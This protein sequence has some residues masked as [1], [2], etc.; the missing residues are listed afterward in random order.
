M[1]HTPPHAL[2]FDDALAR[3]VALGASHAMPVEHVPLARAH[4]RVL[5]VDVSAPIDLQPFDNSAMDGFALR[6]ADL[7]GDGATLLLAGEQFAGV[8]AGLAVE[9]GQCVRITTGAPMPA[10][11]DTVAIKEQV[12]VTIDDDG[13]RFVQVPGGLA[14]GANVRRAGEDARV[15]ERMLVAGTR[16]SPVQVSLASAL[17]IA[18]LAMARRPTVAVF[19][20]GDELV[21]PGLPLQR[22]QVYESNRELLMG[23]LRMQGLEP[24]A[25]PTLPDEAGRM[26]AM[27]ADACGAFDVVITCGGVSAGER[28]LL[29]G[30]LDTHGTRSVWKVAMKP[31]MPVMAGKAGRAVMLG[32]PGNPVSVLATF[33]ALGIP[34]LD[35]MQGAAR[36]PDLHARLAAPLD[37][38][39]ARR[40][41]VRGVLA[42]GTDGALHVQPHAAG[43]SHRLAAAA[44]CNALIDLPEG[45]MQLPAGA[46][47]RVLP[48]GGWP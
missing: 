12:R 1:P 21:A 4:G 6:H 39:N 27:L 25:W 13:G 16:L 44:G 26:H 5:A 29:P 48:Y 3:I 38:R 24:T 22:G 9:S 10:G 7:G 15:G 36:R 40:E 37:K 20:T 30:W 2:P 47:V 46:P 28:D 14:R 43:G 32:L 17:G 34:L 23:L 45:S 18:T 41:F 11:A 19:A 33:V 35:S 31:G 8:D 42:T